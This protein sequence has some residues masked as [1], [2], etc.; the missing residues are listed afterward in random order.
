MDKELHL[1]LLWQ[2]S[3]YKQ[4]EILD[5]IQKNLKISECIEI[6]WTKE[7]VASNFTRFYGVKLPNRSFKEKECGRGKFLLITVWDENPK[8]EYVETSRGF[9]RVNTNLFNLKS[10]YRSWTKGGH[11]IH[12]TNTIPETNHDIT[13]LLGINYNDYIKT[14]PEA[15][16]GQIRSIKRDITGC[17][18]WKDLNEFF[19]TLNATI[20]Y[21]VLRNYEIL[22][23]QY[24]NDLHGDIDLLTDNYNDMV[25][26]TNAK[27]VFKQSY[28]VH[29]KIRI[30]DTDVL[31]DFRYI[32]DNY[33]YSE[34]EENI[35]CNRE[36]NDKNIYV[37]NN[38]N[39]LYSL[40]YHCL[41]HKKKIA[42]DYYQKVKVLFDNAKIDNKNKI[43]EYKYP[44]DYYY[45]IL[46]NFMYSN[47]YQYTKPKDLSVYYNEKCTKIK[48]IEKWLST[49]YNISDI[50]P[51]MLGVFY[52]TSGYQFLT[53]YLNGRK[54]FIK[55]GGM[56]NSVVNEFK[57]G[58][59]LYEQNNTNFIEPILFNFNNN[60]N[61]IAMEFIEGKMLFD[62]M[63][64]ENISEHQ[65]ELFVK[66]LQ[67]IAESLEAKEIL[68]RDIRP[69]NIIVTK[70]NILKL[71]DLQ[72]ATGYNPFKIKRHLLK[73]W[74]DLYG[75]GNDYKVSMYCWDDMYSINKIIN[76]LGCTNKEIEQKIGLN[77]VD[78]FYFR[79]LFYVFMVIKFIYKKLFIK[80]RI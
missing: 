50:R 75:L 9:E 43:N 18:G 70:D 1:I 22:P 3:R 19:Y 4:Q 6:E 17:H 73:R 52:T 51:Y 79:I 65:K 40:I 58:K 15:W 80:N 26:L 33:Y 63:E 20:N 64:K 30:A 49:H 41:I 45:E 31:F 10:K 35:L 69:Q 32:G 62:I 28:R 34:F 48:H 13:L 47:H 38:E 12:S 11:K 37:P 7:N 78:L 16:N 66:Q 77:R 72:F 53:G 5:D 21:C 42:A 36:L 27:P 24:K 54:I 57:I 67:D 25:F 14:A 29:H 76:E 2:N 71:I 39:A 44:F 46:N 8:Y 59:K 68:H 60:R 56:A 23:E 74:Y 61:F 55:W